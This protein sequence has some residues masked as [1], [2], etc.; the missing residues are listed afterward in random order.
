M[1]IIFLI[2][3]KSFVYKNEIK[4]DITPSIEY[5]EWKKTLL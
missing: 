5:Y 2:L 3:I 4:K 1:I